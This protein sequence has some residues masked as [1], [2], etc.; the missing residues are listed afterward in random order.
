MNENTT[1]SPPALPPANHAAPATGSR[2]SLATCHDLCSGA[3]RG[4]REQSRQAETG[5]NG[6]Q[7]GTTPR[8]LHLKQ[9]L[10]QHCSGA[11]TPVAPGAP[12]VSPCRYEDNAPAPDIAMGR[13]WLAA[14][15]DTLRRSM[16]SFGQKGG[17]AMRARRTLLAHEERIGPPSR[18][19]KHYFQN[20]TW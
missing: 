15:R 3:V 18:A 14:V 20:Y 4:N 12:R 8:E 17:R 11:A 5:P 16:S 1:T 6:A 13:S 19:P 2:A 9:P 10:L 7:P